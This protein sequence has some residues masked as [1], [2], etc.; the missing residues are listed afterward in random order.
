[1]R[2]EKI[3]SHQTNPPLYKLSVSQT[4]VCHWVEG[5]PKPSTTLHLQQTPMAHCR[6]AICPLG[7]S[8]G[9][10]EGRGKRFWSS[11]N[12]CLFSDVG[13]SGANRTSQVLLT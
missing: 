12:P 11:E 1:M 8:K 6:Q 4:W 2:A 3:K 7:H 10:E 9:R 5:F 13:S